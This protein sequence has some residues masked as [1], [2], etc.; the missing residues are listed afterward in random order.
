MRALN[1]KHLEDPREHPCEKPD[2]PEQDPTKRHALRVKNS[3]DEPGN[4]TTLGDF[5]REVLLE[6][7]P[8]TSYKRE[9]RDGP[10][11]PRKTLNQ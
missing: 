10:T 2:G 5:I 11:K 7:R 3:E 9:S 8:H 1:C 4:R 6:K